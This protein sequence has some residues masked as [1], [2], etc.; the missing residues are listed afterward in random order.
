MVRK[1]RLALAVVLSVGVVA[2]SAAALGEM[3]S[4]RDGAPG[5]AVIKNVEGQTVGSLQVED[6]GNGKSKIT[7]GVT[8]LP[9]G[10]HGFQVHA[11]GVCDAQSK[12]P[13]TGS[14]FFSAGGTLRLGLTSPRPPHGRS[15]QPVGWRGR[16]W[17]HLVGDRSVPDGSTIRQ[18]WQ[19]HHDPR[20]G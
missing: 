10:F 3:M 8:N 17:H 1:A 13:T 15:A 7:V 6:A 19:R 2:L 4:G 9:A 12:D 16:Y 20:P 14:P 5:G 11:E 18:R